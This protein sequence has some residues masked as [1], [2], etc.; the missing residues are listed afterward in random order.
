MEWVRSKDNTLKPATMNHITVSLSKVLKLARDSGA[1]ESVPE[2]PRT[3]RKDNPTPFFRFYPLV[4][5][6]ASQNTPLQRSA[7]PGKGAFLTAWFFSKLGLNVIE[8]AFE[9]CKVP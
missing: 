5:E 3:S 7:Q 9:R 6:E 4:P 8:L 1:I 2:L